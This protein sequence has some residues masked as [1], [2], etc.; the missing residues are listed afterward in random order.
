MESY[1]KRKSVDE[2]WNLL[3]IILVVSQPVVV[4]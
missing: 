1:G 4:G 2:E 3:W